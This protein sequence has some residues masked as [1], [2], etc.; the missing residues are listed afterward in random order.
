M[1]INQPLQNKTYIVINYKTKLKS[2][3]ST[4][5]EKLYY[6]MNEP[7]FKKLKIKIRN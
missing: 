5:A 3:F 1:N 7:L 4:A 2:K 6:Q